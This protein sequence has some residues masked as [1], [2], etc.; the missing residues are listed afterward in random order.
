M[1]YPAS[2]G[3]FGSSWRL[4][5]HLLWLFHSSGDDFVEG[6]FVGSET[7][8]AVALGG[9]VKYSVLSCSEDDLPVDST[10]VEV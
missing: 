3:N 5:W 10:P 7:G 1:K 8:M 2:S 6:R 4:L 9:E